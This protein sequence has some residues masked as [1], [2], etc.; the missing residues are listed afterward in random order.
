MIPETE[1]L[2]YS[3]SDDKCFD[4]IVKNISPGE[5]ISLRAEGVNFDEDVNDIFEFNIYEDVSI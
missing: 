1:V 2:N 5:T 3:L 4:F